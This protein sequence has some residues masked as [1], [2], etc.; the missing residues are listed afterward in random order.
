MNYS[1]LEYFLSR[2]RITRYLL[3]AAGNQ[4]LAADLYLDNLK[5]SQAFNPLLSVYEVSL[6]NAINKVLGIYFQDPDWIITEKLGFMV[7]PSL[8]TRDR[9]G[10]VTRV[11]DFLLKE[12][13]KAENSIRRNNGYPSPDKVVAEVMFGFWTSFFDRN[14]STILQG[15]PMRIFTSLPSGT[16]RSN[17]FDQ[18]YRVRQ[19]RN[20]IS[21][22]EAIC[23][24]GTGYECSEASRVYQI[25]INH[26][27]WMDADIMLWVASL[28]NVQDQLDHMDNT[29]L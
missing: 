8:Q 29:Y 11:N 25:I 4:N 5:L 23:F 12:V 26:L 1:K 22:N 28:D 6:R 7:H 19:L 2:P 20:R 27:S 9:F 18:L 3:A 21:H 10:N 24:N 16:S 13:N 17:I 15:F 14:Y